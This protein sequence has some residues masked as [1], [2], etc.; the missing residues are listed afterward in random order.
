MSLKLDQITVG[1]FVEDCCRTEPVKGRVIR[2]DEN[3]EDAFI[4]KLTDGRTVSVGRR[5]L[6]KLER[7]A[8]SASPSK[9][10]G[11]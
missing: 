8:Y 9:T 1:D 10:L 4:V 2:R 7:R 5:Y 6:R 11:E 3:R